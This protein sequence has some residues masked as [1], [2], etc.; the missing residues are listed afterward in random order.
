MTQT[1]I[2]HV[3]E[4]PT[5]PYEKEPKERWLSRVCGVPFGMPFDIIANDHELQIRIDG[6]PKL[7]HVTVS[8]TAERVLRSWIRSHTMSIIGTKRIDGG[9]AGVVICD[10]HMRNVLLTR[11][12]DKHPNPHFRLKLCFIG[13][14]LEPDEIPIDGMLRE[15]YE[16][17]RDQR[18]ADEIAIRALL[19][20]LGTLGLTAKSRK[21]DSIPYIQN[22]YLAMAADVDMY[23]RWRSALLNDGPMSGTSEATP[24]E[25]SRAELQRMVS[26]DHVTPG[27]HF[28]A[29][30]HLPIAKAIL[31]HG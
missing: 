12:D 15:L 29:D 27:T 23:D 22:A 17:V 1:V 28:M 10:P 30:L 2:L 13:G 4:S 25:V 20:P 7:T 19:R 21:G 6:D 9:G 18:T 11:K 16:E 3:V 14:S 26:E 24:V 8:T 31:N 5:K